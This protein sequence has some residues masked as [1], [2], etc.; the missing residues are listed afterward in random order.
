MFWVTPED[1]LTKR[2]F[3]LELSLEFGRESNFD[4]LVM[5]NYGCEI[6]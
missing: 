3:S 1:E 4:E 6:T 5:E 2:N